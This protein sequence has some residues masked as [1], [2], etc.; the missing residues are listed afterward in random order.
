MSHIE[1]AASL[2]T[3]DQRTS[4][5]KG[6]TWKVTKQECFV[7]VVPTFGTYTRTTQNIYS[8]LHVPLVTPASQRENNSRE[9]KKRMP[10]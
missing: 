3:L 2:Y 6:K 9:L 8:E 1:G 4:E 7:D 5:I 10:C